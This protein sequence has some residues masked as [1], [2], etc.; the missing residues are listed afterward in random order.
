MLQSIITHHPQWQIVTAAMAEKS[1]PQHTAAHTKDYI[2]QQY[3]KILYDSHIPD[4]FKR[5]WL[6]ACFYEL[7][8]MTDLLTKYQKPFHA[9]SIITTSLLQLPEIDETPVQKMRCIS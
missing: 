2:E 7:I 1:T 9:L 5:E 4:H 3:Q 8:T 6:A